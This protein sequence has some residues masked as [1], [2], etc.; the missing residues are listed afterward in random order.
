MLPAL[1]AAAWRE[2][3]LAGAATEGQPAR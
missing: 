3:R 2:A 1:T